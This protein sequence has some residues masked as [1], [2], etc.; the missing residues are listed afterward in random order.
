MWAAI[1]NNVGAGKRAGQG[2]CRLGQRSQGGFTAL[3]F[4]VRAGRIEA[5]RALV[6]SGANVNDTM[7][8]GTS[9]LV[10]AII[11]AHYE[12]AAE[13]VDRGA[14]VNADAQGW[15]PLHQLAWTRR[16]NGGLANPAAVPDRDAR[17]L[18]LASRL[19]AA[20]RAARRTA[21]ERIAIWGWTT[22]II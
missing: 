18:D 8:D 10:L 22:G 5:V 17:Q 15:T 9:A 19:L 6:E 13:L 11:N 21:E 3:L 7:P 1:E 2:G 16:P 20:R 4:A 14:D 12:L